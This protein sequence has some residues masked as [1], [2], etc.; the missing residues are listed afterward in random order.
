MGIREKTTTA[1][2]GAGFSLFTLSLGDSVGGPSFYTAPGFDLTA[3]AADNNFRGTPLFLEASN[4][5]SNVTAHIAANTALNSAAI[6][7]AVDIDVC[8]V[9]LP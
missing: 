4:A 9:V 2:S 7:G 1:W 3:A 5:G 6:I 8:W